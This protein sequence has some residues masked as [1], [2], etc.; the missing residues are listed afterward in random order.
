MPLPFRRKKTLP[1]RAWRVMDVGEGI[2]V[3][4]DPSKEHLELVPGPWP[5]RL[6]IGNQFDVQEEDPD[7]QL[8][9]EMDGI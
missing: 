4:C 2:L 8:H 1:I 9:L 3:F 7:G 5:G 6:L